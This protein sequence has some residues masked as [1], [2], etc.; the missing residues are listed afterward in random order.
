MMK[1]EE[2]QEYNPTTQAVRKHNS[3]LH[4]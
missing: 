1:S 4:S 2:E 3:Y